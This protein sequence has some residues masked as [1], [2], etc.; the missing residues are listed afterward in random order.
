VSRHKRIPPF[1]LRSRLDL[2]FKVG[3]LNIEIKRNSSMPFLAP[4]PEH[5]QQLTKVG[6]IYRTDLEISLLKAISASCHGL[7]MNV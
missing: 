4:Q 6:W 2:G 5:Y 7:M 1:F 3:C